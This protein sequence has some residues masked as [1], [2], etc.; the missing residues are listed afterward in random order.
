V[1][2]PDINLLAYAYNA[3]DPRHDQARDWWKRR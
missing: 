2:L 3:A 1:I